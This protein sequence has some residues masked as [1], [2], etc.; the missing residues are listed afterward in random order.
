MVTKICLSDVWKI[1]DIRVPSL[2][3]HYTYIYTNAI[4]VFTGFPVSRELT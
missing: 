3:I 1:R 2:K 4:Y